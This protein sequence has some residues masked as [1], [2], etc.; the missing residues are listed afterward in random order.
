MTSSQIKESIASL[1]HWFNSVKPFLLYR[2][3]D[4]VLIIPP[5][6]VYKLNSTGTSLLKYLFAGGS[7]EK[8]P[9]C[10]EKR[11]RDIDR[12]FR[13]IQDCMDGK[14]VRTE[15]VRYEFDF[16]RLPVLGEIAVTKRC[17]N[18]CLFCYA[19]C[20][21][22]SDYRE[23]STGQIKKIIRIFRDKAKIPFFSFTGGEPLLRKDLETLVAYALKVGLRTNLISNGTLIT[24]ERALSLY[25]AGLRTAQISLE[26]S[27]AAIHDRLCGVEGAFEKTI[28]GIKALKKAQIAVQT[29][30]TICA[31]NKDTIE[32]MPPFLEG[33]GINRFSM[34]MYIPSRK[35]PLNHD[36]YISYSEIGDIVDKINS[37]AQRCG[38]TFFWYSPTPFCQFNPVAR[39]L[40]NKA[41]AAMDGLISVNC[42]GEVFPCSSYE[43]PIGNLLK[44]KFD[45]VWYSDRARYFKEK[46]Y[47]PSE[48]LDCSAFSACQ[49]ACPLYWEACGTSELHQNKEKTYK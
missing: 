39:G 41:C 15:S 12:F 49:A 2:A 26:S 35:N 46:K 44:K 48:C 47:A 43:E 1:S 20:P 45:T 16:T 10:N 4:D 23:M 32:T 14:G 40:G 28:E 3:E 6:M 24:E 30:T 36:L 42:D 34:N 11:I 25:R 21:G 13:N 5:N 17:N 9:D 29:N 22:G 8:I 18:R 7:L 37:E 27:E 19:G 38:L 31:L 33:L